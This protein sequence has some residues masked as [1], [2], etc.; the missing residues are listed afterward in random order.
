MMCALSTGKYSAFNDKNDRGM[1]RSRGR[2][3][4]RRSRSGEGIVRANRKVS[5]QCVTASHMTSSCHQ[6]RWQ[7]YI[8]YLTQPDI[9]PFK[10]ARCCKPHVV[11]TYMLVSCKNCRASIH[12][13][14][15][16]ASKIPS[17][18]LD[19]RVFGIIWVPVSDTPII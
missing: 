5:T 14:V 18:A 10:A 12:P 16:P 8:E 6:T 19:P 9:A 2:R 3:A 4:R 13:P 11:A 1:E 17:R 15:D 7:L